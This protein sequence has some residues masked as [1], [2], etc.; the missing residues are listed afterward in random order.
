[1]DRLIYTA[2]AGIN[3]RRP[4]RQVQANDLANV[5]TVGFKKSFEQALIAIF[6]HLFLA[7]RFLALSQFLKIGCKAACSKL[8]MIYSFWCWL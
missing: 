4:Q 1:M 6:A 5:S 7:S 8:R 2:L 3:E